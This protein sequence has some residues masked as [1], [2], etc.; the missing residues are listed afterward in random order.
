MIKPILFTLKIILLPL[1]VFGQFEV[2]WNATIDKELTKTGDDA[3]YFYNELHRMNTGWRFDLAQANFLSTIKFNSHWTINTQFLIERRGGNRIGFFKELD[4]YVFRVPQLNV[5]WTS[6]N[7]KWKVKAGRILS[8][9]G[10]FYKNQLFKDRTILPTPLVY[11]Y[12]TNMS[13]RRGFIVDLAEENKVELEEGMDWGT[14]TFYR[15]GYHSG[16]QV[17]FIKSEKLNWSFAIIGNNRDYPFGTS[18][19]EELSVV[20]R[21]GYNP[22]YFSEL[23]LSLSYGRLLEDSDL[24]IDLDRLGQ[25]SK[26]DLGFDYKLGKGFF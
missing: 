23:G 9:F 1:V 21:V 13:F 22:S 6:E 4:A 11:S 3:H 5:Q 16:L 15:L 7:E 26:T 14:S 24:N 8:P 19:I 20:S 12:Y 10:L 25:Y 17:N 18:N 2:T